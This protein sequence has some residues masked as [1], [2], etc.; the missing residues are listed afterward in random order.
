MK[1]FNLRSLPGNSFNRADERDSRRS[2]ELVMLG[3][4]CS[5]RMIEGNAITLIRAT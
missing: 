1:P 2:M 3:E 4:L 5:G